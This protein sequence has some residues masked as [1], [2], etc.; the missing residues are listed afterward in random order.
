MTFYSLLF[1]STPP[2]PLW[3]KPWCPLSGRLVSLSCL[4][5]HSTLVLW[6]PNRSAA[7][8]HLLLHLTILFGTTNSQVQCARTLPPRRNLAGAIDTTRDSQLVSVCAP[9]LNSSATLRPAKEKKML[10]PTRVISKTGAQR[11]AVK[12]RNISPTSV[13]ARALKSCGASERARYG[14]ASERLPSERAWS[15]SLCQAMSAHTTTKRAGTWTPPPPT[16]TTRARSTANGPQPPA[17]V[18]RNAKRC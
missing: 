9:S 1:P 4:A 16:T 2:P 17:I 15:L 18:L 3:R 6:P 8:S 11:Q 14:C 10:R 13:R 12:L 5:S 7:G